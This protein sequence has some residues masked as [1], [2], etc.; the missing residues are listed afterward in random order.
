M[1][2]RVDEFRVSLSDGASVSARHFVSVAGHGAF[3]TFVFAHGAGAG[4]RHPFMVTYAEGLVTRG[5]ETVTFDFPY[6]EA[7]RRLPDRAPVLEQAFLAVIRAVRG[8]PG[9]GSRPLFIG[10]KSMGG[11]MASHVA[12]RHAAEAGPVAGLVFFGYPL[13]APGRPAQRREAHLPDVAAPMLFVQGERDAFGTPDE[14]RPVLA[15]LTVPAELA[16]VDTGDH[17]LTV[18]RAS[19]RSASDVRDHVLDGVVAWMRATV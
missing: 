3:A 1:P 17:S 5:V 18:P 12:A 6:M 19:G 9:A 4:Q 16:V 10:G 8:R 14:L 11:R 7:G 2:H 15:R 13:H